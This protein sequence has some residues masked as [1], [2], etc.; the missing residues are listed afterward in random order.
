[1]ENQE[2]NQKKEEERHESK[3]E[4]ILG[5]GMGFG[6][7]GAF[8]YSLYTVLDKLNYF[9][10]LNMIHQATE[11]LPQEQINDLMT[12]EYNVG[13]ISGLGGFAIIMGGIQLG[14]YIGE[15]ITKYRERSN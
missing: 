12:I 13:F 10:H 8:E 2:E 6:L 11:K 4:S 14:A 7:L 3:L 5:L 1:M 9:D 15:K